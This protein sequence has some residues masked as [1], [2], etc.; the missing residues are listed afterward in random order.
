RGLRDVVAPRRKDYDLVHEA[1][2]VRLYD[3]LAPHVV[4]HNAAVV[5]GIGA[6]RA[7][8]GRYAY[9]NLIMGAMMMEYARRAGVEKFLVVGTIWSY[10]TLAPAPFREDDRWS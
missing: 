10:P 2:V 5:A 1:D 8:P 6:N 4:V 7:N 9:E 3:E